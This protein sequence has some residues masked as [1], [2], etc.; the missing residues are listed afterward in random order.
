MD[1]ASN[2]VDV[3]IAAL[4]D[5]TRRR[6]VE[7]LVEAPRRTNELAESVG[8]S[9]P[10]VSRHLRV[11]RDRGL[12]VRVDVEGD[13]RGRRY[14]L[15]PECL[16]SLAS[17]LGGHHW[18]RALPNA[19]LAPS[20]D[21]LG[22]FLE[23]V[24]GFLDAFAASDSGFF[25]RH[26]ADDVELYFP[27]ASDPWDKASTVASVEGHAP[28]V[29]WAITRSSVRILAPG[30][31]MVVVG[32]VVRTAAAAGGTPVVQS[33]IFDDRN[34]PWLLRFLQQSPGSDS[35]LPSPTEGNHHD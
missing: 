18:S 32:T 23:R 19:A 24:G 2:P 11:L 9:V 6:V 14:E 22:V 8:I 30:L 12:V 13:G 17:W 33:M 10:A 35:S 25:E 5:P 27:G 34:D 7:L 29:E 31:T 4:A 28:Y 3:A 1:S 26:L 20:G 21:D 15:A 16:D